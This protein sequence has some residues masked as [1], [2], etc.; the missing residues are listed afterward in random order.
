MYGFSQIFI[1]FLILNPK[2]HT[3]IILFMS[4]CFHPRFRA[5]AA[6]G[7]AE[8]ELVCLRGG[9]VLSAPEW[10]R[11]EFGYLVYRAGLK[12]DGGNSP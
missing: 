11:F 3:P 8:I 9:R 12:Q 7:L 2:I 1:Q 5:G 4:T 10:K 6:M